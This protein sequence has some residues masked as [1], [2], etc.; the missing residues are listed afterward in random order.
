MIVSVIGGGAWGTA[1]AANS[2][3]AG[4][5]TRLWA[6]DPALAGTLARGGGNPR[7]LSGIALPGPIDADSDLKRIVRDCDAILLAVPAQAMR[8]TADLLS[9][10]LAEGM[11]A[12][13]CAK[14][15]ERGSLNTMAEVLAETLP[16][17]APVVLS[18]PTFADEVAEGLPAAVTLA[19][20][21]NAPAE[22]IRAAVGTDR[23]RP[24]IS[25]DIVG[26][27]LC[28]A[29]KNVVAIG[30]G[31]VI[32]RGLGE[33]AR[34]ALITRGLAEIGRL[35]AAM[36]GRA[37]TTAGLSGLGDLTLTST[38]IKSRN[39]SFGME[40]GRGRAGDDILKNRRSV[41]EGYHTAQAICELARRTGVE[42]PICEAVAAILNG[43]IAIDAA[44]ERLLSRPYQ[45]EHP[46][47]NDAGS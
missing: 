47:S 21:D 19:A 33:N 40:L 10:H 27:E 28:G 17:A 13:I 37:E 8:K 22:V 1:L 18:G 2:V 7:Y 6:R 34:A 12:A 14:G 41:T 38:S 5:E 46:D 42:L 35:V 23:F 11:P 4:H 32:G 15:I 16:G 31:I 25:H 45:S 29:A 24:Y 30:A 39:Y 20:R 26:V 9:P 36:G 44:V 43:D 3:R